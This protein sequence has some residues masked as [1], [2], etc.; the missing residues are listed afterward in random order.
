MCGSC[1]AQL[2]VLHPSRQKNFPFADTERGATASAYY[3]SILISAKLNHLD[4]EKYLA[5]VFRELTEHDLSPESIE[6]ILPYSD[7]LP[8]TLESQIAYQR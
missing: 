8:D 5:Y 2:A 6:R 7:Q 3:F 4:P 1:R